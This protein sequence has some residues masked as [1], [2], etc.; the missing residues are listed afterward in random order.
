MGK[1]TRRGKEEFGSEA[2]RGF[3][4]DA[5]KHYLRKVWSLHEVEMRV[6]I[7]TCIFIHWA[8]D[9]SLLSKDVIAILEDYD[10]TICVSSETL[11]ELVIQFNKGKLVSK[12][13]KTARQM[14][15]SIQNDYFISVLPLKSEH[16]LTYSDLRI[17]ETQDHNDPSDHVIIAHAITEHLPLV[18]G[19]G[20]FDFYRAQGL[21]LI[22]NE[23]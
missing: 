22:F 13:W 19:D 5:R 11:R 1:L 12:F 6:L 21:D 23:K 16:M 4:Q 9:K 18:S 20:K 10:N 15:E 17:N 2:D 7:D 3:R 8:T 14:L